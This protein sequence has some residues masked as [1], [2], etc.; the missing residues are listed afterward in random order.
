MSWPVQASG[1]GGSDTGIACIAATA[2]AAG[3]LV[4]INAS[5]QMALADA[6]AEGKEAV[7]FTKE[8]VLSGAVGAYFTNGV[9]P[10]QTGLTPG[11]NY[12]LTTT[13]GLAGAA[14]STT[15]NV[16]QK[17]GVATSSTEIVFAPAVPITL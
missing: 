1:G 12:F 16:V 5:S 11:T 3:K 8:A 4:Y 10:S 14:P 7:G 17:I 6:T 13:P 2:I 9:I 15:G